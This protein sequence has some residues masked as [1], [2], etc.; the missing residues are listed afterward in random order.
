MQPVHPKVNQSWIF[1][2]MTDAEAE[3]LLLY[4]PDAKHPY[5]KRPWFWDRLKMGQEGDA[6]GNMAGWHHQ[7]DGY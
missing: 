4:L 5:L 3:I 2:G 6:N 1:I 7:L